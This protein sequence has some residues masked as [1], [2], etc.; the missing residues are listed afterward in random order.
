MP[1]RRENADTWKGRGRAWSLRLFERSPGDGLNRVPWRLVRLLVWLGLLFATIVLAVLAAPTGL[2]DP[3]IVEFEVAGTGERSLE[4]LTGW[5]SSGRDDAARSIRWDYVFIVAYS[6]TLALACL[7]RIDETRRRH[8]RAMASTAAAA[9]VVAGLLDVAENLFLQ[10]QIDR[11]DE[12]ADPGAYDSDAVWAFV[13]AVS[14]FLLIGLV[15]VFLLSLLP[16]RLRIPASTWEADP[17]PLHRRPE[18]PVF[19]P[20]RPQPIT[21]EPHPWDPAAD[22]VGICCSGGGIRSA[23]FSLGALQALQ[24]EGTLDRARYVTAVSGGSYIATAFAIANTE[25]GPEADPPVFSEGS[26]EERHLRNNTSYLAPDGVAR[27]AGGFRA[28]AGIAFNLLL[29]WLVLF[30][31]AQ[32]VG[33]FIS[34]EW[35]H[36]RLRAREPVVAIQEHPR[37]D[38]EDIVLEGGTILIAEVDGAI[39]DLAG[40]YF[41]GGDDEGVAIE[42]AIE[43]G[44]VAIVDADNGD[45][46]RLVIVDQPILVVRELPFDEYNVDDTVPLFEF[47]KQLK[48]ELRSEGA[49]DAIPDGAFT[50]ETQPELKVNSGTIGSR[51]I[52]F[53]KWMWQP[54]VALMSA[55]LLVYWMRILS[56]PLSS[57]RVRIMN[58]LSGIL[59]GLGAAS[60]TLLTALPW[61]V[62][63]APTAVADAAR[64]LPDL[65][66]GAVEEEDGPGNLAAWFIGIAGLTIA[67]VITF[68]K[69]RPTLIAKLLTAVLLPLFALFVFVEALELAAANGPFGQLSGLGFGWGPFNSATRFAIAAGVLVLIW[70]A[71]DAQSWSLYPYYKRALNRAFALRRTSV[72]R[73]DDATLPSSASSPQVTVGEEV[74][75]AK[76]ADGG[77][78]GPDP[79]RDWTPGL[80][81]APSADPQLRSGALN[82]SRYAKAVSGTPGSGPELIVCAAV[83]L[84]DTGATPP[85]RK[86]GSFTFSPTEIG[87]PDVGYLNMRDLEQ[88]FSIARLK[89]VTMIAGVAISGAAVS[90]G[91]GKMTFGVLD[92]LLAVANVRLGVW[93]PNP[94]WVQA[95]LAE[96]I[97][98]ADGPLTTWH[99]RP[100]ATYF[101]RELF[102]RF[103]QDDR[104]LYVTDG[105]HWENLGL[106]EL[107]RRGCTEIWCLNASGGG[108]DS[109]TT[110]GEA[111]ALAREELGVSINIDPTPLRPPPKLPDTRKLRLF[112]RQGSKRDPTPESPCPFA[113]GDITYPDGTEGRLIVLKPAITEPENSSEGRDLP[114][115]VQAW[116][117]ASGSF[118]EDS[119]AKQLFT[120]RQFESY[121]RLGRYQADRALRA[122]SPDVRA[123]A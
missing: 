12:S 37:V 79:P 47:E 80:P 1:N 78:A 35:V 91:M 111:I 31:I 106:V 64:H 26:P 99:D 95:L 113:I 74:D 97:G 100:R 20:G 21:A 112:R 58:W 48:L 94:Q 102:G 5:G 2:P 76:G 22:R 61:I 23:S 36:P 34:S 25:S 60:F 6:T 119:T 27:I 66:G 54:S 104:Y 16:Q 9:A 19:P 71:F 38:P 50:V 118:P 75:Y 3:G 109:F 77:P 69:R 117:E 98:V 114:W 83:N 82:F 63:E 52:E 30:V 42:F 103:K 59:F 101:G 85:G 18:G 105:G 24:E 72:S 115:D 81:Q 92:R 110:L 73:G 87:G 90:P 65:G 15:L 33:W 116:A 28:V 93:L 45:P 84:S 123:G 68:V 57:Q 89:D 108:N 121:R 53:R 39:V 88:A 46:A 11:F 51:T 70:L 62:Q 67:Q 107:L 7:W 10:A 43:P 122:L 86:S 41:G 8:H 14:K 4:I 17:D 120:D 29:I 32:P 40:R 55:A 56:R 44:R 49:I 96:R 13:F